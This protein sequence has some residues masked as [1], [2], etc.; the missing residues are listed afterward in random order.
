[1]FFFAKNVTH[2][3]TAKKEA[4]ELCTY[5]YTVAFCLMFLGGLDKD[6]VVVVPR[7]VMDDVVVEVMEYFGDW[8]VRMLLVSYDE[9]TWTN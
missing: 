3:V 2:T 6:E 8:H 4:C 9:W 1:M 7:D 5:L